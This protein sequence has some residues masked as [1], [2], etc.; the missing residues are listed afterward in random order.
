MIGAS[1]PSRERWILPVIL[2][3]LG[4][5]LLLGRVVGLSVDESYATVMS[6]QLSLS[7]FD[8]PPMMFWWAGLAA[9]LTGSEDRLVVRLPFIL[10]FVATTWLLSRLGTFLFGRDAGLWTAVLLNVSLFFSVVAGGWVLPDGPLLLFSAGAAYCLARAVLPT[11]G[12]GPWLEANDPP[13]PEARPWWI[14]FGAC[15]GLALLAKYHGCFL[16]LGAGAFL[17]TSRRRAAW[18]ARPDPYLALASSI[19]LFTP[20]LAWNLRHDWASFRFQTGRAAPIVDTWGTPF[21]DT[22]GGQATWILPWIWIPLVIVLFKGIL[23]GPRDDG[24]WLLVCL[25]AGP[26]FGF[27][28]LTAFGSRG[29]PHW[30]A[31]GYFMLLPLLGASVARRLEHGRRGGTLVWLAGCVAGFFLVLAGFLAHL[32]TGWIARA[33][34]EVL[35]RGDPTD[36]LLD[37]AP[38]AEQLQAWRLP[39]PGAVLATARWDDAAKLA[40]AMGASHG[41]ALPGT[42]AKTGVSCVGEDARGFAYVRDPEADLGGDIVLVV[43]R[44]PGAEPMRAYAPFFA[45]LRSVGSVSIPRGN[46][47]G[48]V[49]SVY[50]GTGLKRRLPRLRSL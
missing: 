31:P 25:G 28:L 5:R 41:A 40:Y 20:V 34:P 9:R 1:R 33:A 6:R 16:L 2:A 21:L 48:V 47:D 35:S 19:L 49:V 26:I 17:A 8:H 13:R 3:S 39:A 10:A 50:F 11:N 30:E 46:T 43:R 27:T 32:Q 24:R 36:D 7:Y 37:W 15:T 18:L 14:G 12:A 38:V 29:L 4:L 44:R 42:R 23:S 22:L 45:S